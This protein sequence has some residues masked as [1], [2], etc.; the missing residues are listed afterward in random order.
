MKRLPLVF[1]IISLTLSSCSLFRKTVSPTDTEWSKALLSAPEFKGAHWRNIVFQAKM[2]GQTFSSRGTCRIITDSA[3]HISLTPFLGMEMFK[4]ELG[5][6]KLSVYD[7]INHNLYKIEYSKNDSSSGLSWVFGHLQDIILNRP[8]I[9]APGKDM[10]KTYQFRDKKHIFVFDRRRFTQ[11]LRLNKEHRMEFIGMEMRADGT[12]L[13]M[14][15]DEFETG[16]GIS[17]PKSM[18]LKLFKGSQ[19]A[20]IKIQLDKMDFGPLPSL[21]YEDPSR[22]KETSIPTIL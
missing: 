4:V 20:E 15:Y 5:P 12:R 18:E 9:I 3:I 6:H 16:D 11:T 17:F 1:L 21:R 2:G 8:F 22:F 7:K 19:T 10:E 14:N 13:E